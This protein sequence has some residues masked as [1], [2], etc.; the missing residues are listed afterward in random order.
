[1]SGSGGVNTNILIE[2][3]GIF[4][5]G[6]WAINGDNIQSSSIVGLRSRGHK[7]GHIR[8]YDSDDIIAVKEPNSNV[9]DRCTLD[10]LRPD[11][12]NVAS[13]YLFHANGVRI[14][15][16]TI[17]GNFYGSSGVLRAIYAENCD[18]LQIDGLWV[19]DLC[20]GGTG[21]QLIRCRNAVID[22]YHG[23]GGYPSDFTLEMCRG[24]SIRGATLTNSVPHVVSVG[25]NFGVIV[26]DS[27][28]SHPFNTL[29]GR[30][31]GHR[32]IDAQT[33]YH[34]NP[35]PNFTDLVGTN[36][37]YTG[38]AENWFKNPNLV[39]DAAG[40]TFDAAYVSR[41]ET[42]SPGG[43][44]G[45]FLFNPGPT[46]GDNLIGVVPLQ[47]IIS[48][49][50]DMFDN[51]WTVSYDVYIESLG[52]ASHAGRHVGLGVSATGQSEH[53]I[54]WPNTADNYSGLL[55][56]KWYRW[57]TNV[58]VPEVSI[59]GTDRTITFRIKPEE[60]TKGPDT[61]R[62]RIGNFRLAPGR[63][64]QPG[65]L[66]K[67]TEERTHTFR[68]P[69]GVRFS[70]RP[71]AAA[72]PSGEAG[73]RGN[74]GT[75]EEYDH[76][77]STWRPIGSGA[78]GP[79]NIKS[80]PYLAKGD[81]TTDDTAAI[82]DAHDDALAAGKALYGPGGHY[83][84]TGLDLSPKVLF[85]GDG[86]ENT[87]IQSVTNAP[88]IN[89]VGS[90]GFGPQIERL[91]VKGSKTAGTSQIGLK[92]DAASGAHVFRVRDVKIT[93]TGS[94]G[95]FVGKA[96]KSHFENIL[97]DDCAG[98]ALEYDSAGEGNIFDV[99][100]GKVSTSFPAAFRIN[101]GN[102]HLIGGGSFG[103]VRSGSWCAILGRKNGLFGESTDNAAF[104]H[105]ADIEFK[106]YHAGAVYCLRGSDVK[107]S[108]RCLFARYPVQ[109]TIASSG[110]DDTQIAIPVAGNLDDLL[111]PAGPNVV[112]VVEGSNVERIYYGS[113]TVNVLNSCVRSYEGTTAHVFTTAAIVYSAHA[114]GIKY[115]VDTSGSP[116][117]AYKG[118]IDDECLLK[119]GGQY[120]ARSC[121]IHAN[122]L[123]PLLLNGEGVQTPAGTIHS[124]Y[125]STRDR[126]EELMRADGFMPRLK[127][128]GA[129]TFN[130]PGARLIR[131]DFSAGATLTLWK[132]T[133]ER[134]PQPVIIYD[135]AG[136]A[137]TNN[138]ALAAG[139]GS[140][141]NGGA[142]YVINQN[143]G[144]VIV[145]ADAEADT[146]RVIAAHPPQ[147]PTNLVDF[148]GTGNANALAVFDDDNTIKKT[149]L[150]ISGT[151]L[152]TTLDLLPA[153]DNGADLGGVSQRFGYGYFGI[154][155][156]TPLVSLGSNVYVLT[157]S[158][159]PEGAATAGPGS[160]YLRTDGTCYKKLT[161]TGNTGWALQVTVTDG[162][163]GDIVVSASGATWT[164]EN[165]AVTFAKMQN[166]ATDKLLG[167]STA[168]TGDIEEIS[169]GAG[170][171]LTSGTLS[172]TGG[173]GGGGA[174]FDS[175]VFASLP[176]SPAS[177]DVYLVSDGHTLE[178]HD[179]TDWE[180]FGPIY[181]LKP[182][183]LLTNWA[184]INTGGGSIFEDQPRALH[185]FAPYTGANNLRGLD[186]A[187]PGGAYTVTALLE[188][189]ISNQDYHQAGLMF[190]DNSGK[191]ET[192]E[193][194]SITGVFRLRVNRY[195]S[196]TSTAGSTPYNAAFYPTYRIWMR[197]RDDNSSNRL[198]SWSIDSKNWIQ[199]HAEG[200]TNHITAT[201]I[202]F[203]ANTSLAADPINIR[204][205]HWEV[206]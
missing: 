75:L 119:D 106:N 120:Y 141:I 90:G 25:D 179:G 44:G 40:W 28:L 93:E 198:Y 169:I 185:I 186:V 108:G 14:T 94:V 191:Y 195:N 29:Q 51:Y 205:L 115:D 17:Q 13:I 22:G 201:R 159:S 148:T 118:T 97:I 160:I 171:D 92:C 74:N 19:E 114:V 151:D 3:V 42:G 157:G 77:S 204:L 150:T 79:I 137:A 184:Q 83:L 18:T 126:A 203:F 39:D 6:G 188:I 86:D 50:D 163:K 177:D 89:C 99:R 10:N 46:D 38:W 129:F 1:M 116:T 78:G 109:S 52:A 206:L 145:V 146:W 56:E 180:S 131:C 172:A 103:A 165:D 9:I 101:S 111:F 36:A 149:G 175:G 133:L 88:I 98:W 37:L 143:K 110:I 127:I 41:V 43:V 47:Q 153:T 182:P 196:P 21:V 48:I 61:P 170:L 117:L 113:R 192:F 135:G 95:L 194:A 187:A 144:V 81:G 181:R 138:I 65:G 136:D 122:D 147:L 105:F 49:P 161:G 84:V 26:E 193:L 87:I 178:R 202:G 176:A 128:T 15:N 190:G 130:N 12:N 67:I 20:S 7:K 23:S 140:T 62:I 5:F 121:F 142:G 34:S 31:S 30:V 24:V 158:G 16:T 112:Y 55:E 73:L 104:A 154:A 72:P 27:T 124:Y 125:N 11:D 2:N 155:V 64:A 32:Y 35:D 173:G 199:V 71:S 59:A 91:A 76:L 4:N 63:E 139:G 123:P 70:S 57:S 134:Y 54:Q 164:V 102:F 174:Q 166:I 189:Q 200:R 197:I 156:V 100:V 53:T 168:A 68:G 82:Q 33:T 58:Y 85:F 152:V 45:Y 66:T 60:T 80:A 69:D 96:E 8:L 162:Y 132:A 167:R 107:L 183:P